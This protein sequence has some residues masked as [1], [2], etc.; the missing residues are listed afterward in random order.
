[1]YC[2][3]EHRKYDIST[4]YITFYFKIKTEKVKTTYNLE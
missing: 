1:M 3:L 2:N 4:G